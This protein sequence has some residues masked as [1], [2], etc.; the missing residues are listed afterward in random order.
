MTTTKHTILFLAA[1]PHGTD[2]RALDRAARAIHAE[3][4]R[5]GH[6]DRFELV[7]RWAA[8]PLDL[9][10]ELRKLRPTIVH[11]GGRGGPSAPSEHAPNQTAN[12]DTAREKH[13]A[14]KPREHSV[15][16]QGP[17]GQARW[18]SPHA[19]Q[20]TFGAAGSSVQVV[21]LDACHSASYAEA[22]LAEVDCI[23][24]MPGTVDDD[25]ARS[26]AIG[27]YGGL[28]DGESIATAYRQGCA[29]IHLEGLADADR[30]QLAVREGTNPDTLV[31]AAGAA[32]RGESAAATPEVRVTDTRTAT[33]ARP[34][35]SNARAGNAA[36][37]RRVDIGI[38]TIRDDEFR[39]VLDAFPAKAGIFKG[40]HREYTLRHA[41]ASG[42]QRYTL[43][44]LRQIEQ[45]NGEAQS[46]ARDL[47]QDLA[48][49]LILVVGIAGGLPSDDVR[50]G[51]VVISTR[52]HD[53]T[54]GATRFGESD[55][56]S[57]TGGPID[58]E[59]AAA[60]ANLQGRED[61]LGD[62]N[63]GLPSPPSVSWKKKGQLYGPPAWQARLREKMEHHYGKSVPPRAPIYKDGPIASSDRLIK[64]PKALFPWI[65]TARHVLAVEMESGGVFRAAQNSCPMLAIRGIS[66]IV[67]LQR[68]DTWT[69]YACASAAAFTR[70]FLRTRP[71]ALSA[72]D[73]P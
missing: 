24:G 16:L 15:Y 69:K 70:A 25:A 4:E 45:G 1:S 64:D 68:A 72:A 58:K 31:L 17:D 26:F 13:R 43:A 42:G 40:P 12:R 27:F 60:V 2:P 11:F 38:L 61:D 9:L 10:R 8:E 55:T 48:P 67:G 28:G 30:P 23:V 29:A 66:D 19:L 18:V 50:L 53:V 6:R 56:S 54:V 5:S 33:A 22:L 20:D 57:I 37:P 7:T 49:T 62:W 47:I 14:D 39:A 34:G 21:V 32:Y 35:R 44:V 51:D 3:L 36:A 73:P 65:A 52:I 46:A 71:V 63:S 41:D 59:L